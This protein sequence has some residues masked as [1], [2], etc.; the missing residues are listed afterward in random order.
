MKLSVCLVIKNEEKLLP[1]CLESIKKI[2]DE[3]VLIHD[4][5]CSDKSLEIG[6]KHQARVFIRPF[7][8]EAEWHRPYAFEKARGEWIL[9]IDADEFLSNSTAEKVKEL[10]EEKKI[11]AFSFRWPY[12]NGTRYI[13]KGPFAKT[14]KPCLFKKSKLFMIGISHEYPRTY[15]I[16]EKRS[17]IRLEHKPAYNNFTRENFQEKWVG[18]AKLQ[19]RQI[20]AIENAPCFNIANPK[21]NSVFQNYLKMKKHPLISLLIDI[22]KFI[23][24]YLKR[25]IIIAGI[26]SWKIAYMELKYITLVRYFLWRLKNG[27]RI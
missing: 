14:Y 26:D 27:Q 12:W 19:A 10:I 24:I 2:A 17:D 16:L 6:E 5:P 9:Q 8:G 15:G 23:A 25:G 13:T 22:I 7:V 18:W 3:I 20:F 4:G 1:R 11:D 21:D